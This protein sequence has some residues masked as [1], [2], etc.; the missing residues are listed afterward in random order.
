MK[1]NHILLEPY[2]VIYKYRNNNRKIQYNVYIF[3]GNEGVKYKDIFKKIENLD[4]YNTLLSLTLK[5]INILKS[6]YGE[7]WFLYFFN[8]Y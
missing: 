8:K 3:V 5:D 6:G 1:E 4:L 2:K 7:R